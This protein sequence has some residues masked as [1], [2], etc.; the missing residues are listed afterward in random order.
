MVCFPDS[1]CLQLG[2][3]ACQTCL[4][5]ALSH[6]TYE[7]YFKCFW[8]INFAIFY[9]TIEKMRE[10][11]WVLNNSCGWRP[12]RNLCVER[13]TAH[14]SLEFHFL[15]IPGSSRRSSD[16]DLWL[17]NAAL[18][19][20]PARITFSL[21]SRT[22]QWQNPLV[23]FQPSVPHRGHFTVMKCPYSDL[24]KPFFSINFF[25]NSEGIPR[26]VSVTHIMKEHASL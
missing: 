2:W 12:R 8:L 10:G 4:G 24:H 16:I 5:L 1:S 7:G 17:G 11:W 14:T 6:R 23:F 26:L 18:Q 9:L 19:W 20:Q 15:L 3:K 13:T 22:L 21:T 25:H